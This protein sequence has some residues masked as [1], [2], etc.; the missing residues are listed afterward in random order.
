MK[1][2]ILPLIIFLLLFF[3]IGCNNDSNNYKYGKANIKGG[4]A[5]AVSSVTASRNSNLK[6]RELNGEQIYTIFEDGTYAEA[7][8]FGADLP[9]NVNTE[10][11]FTMVSNGLLYVKIIDWYGGLGLYAFDIETEEVFKAELP[12]NMQGSFIASNQNKKD[13]IDIKPLTPGKDGNIYFIIKEN[14]DSDRLAY[15]NP[16]TDSTINFKTPYVKGNYIESF[17]MADDDIIY[18]YGKVFPYRNFNHL[19]VLDPASPRARYAY[20]E[21]DNDAKIKSATAVGSDILI[22]I[23]G[24]YEKRGIFKIESELVDGELDFTITRLFVNN[25]YD[26]VWFSDIS[27]LI[28]LENGT[29]WGVHDYTNYSE[30]NSGV[31]KILDVDGNPDFK[32]IPTRD[33]D[34]NNVQAT[35]I[36]FFEDK[37]FYLYPG[38]RTG[39]HKIAALKLNSPEEPI[40]LTENMDEDFM[41]IFEYSITSSHVY[42]SGWDGI[43]P[44]SGR[45]NIETLELD[46]I[47]EGLSI[48]LIEALHYL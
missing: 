19:Q 21:D 38:K 41:T 20:Y 17:H 4:V 47:T 24:I 35:K 5:V 25:Y 44:I 11:L 31:V 37:V 9:Y 2:F 27:H 10:I 34:G 43:T 13:F 46:I 33:T 29:V 3:I 14:W 12:H 48:D 15:W 8:Q 26:K 1:K 18:I 45:I 36:R 16:R 30:L 6:K 39:T 7:F 28:T 40:D 23:D 42:F 32:F 22:N